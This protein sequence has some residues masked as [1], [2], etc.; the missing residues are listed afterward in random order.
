MA[1]P[2]W[3]VLLKKYHC[4]LRTGLLMDNILPSLH[5]LLTDAEYSCIADKVS[6]VDRVDELVKILLTKDKVT[7]ERFC[8]ALEKNGYPRWASKLRGKG[9]VGPSESGLYVLSSVF[10]LSLCYYYSCQF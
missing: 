7:F 10:N 3:K 1:E 4:K 9:T 8:S 2:A 5:S 6:S